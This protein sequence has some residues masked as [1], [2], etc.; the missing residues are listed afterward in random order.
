MAVEAAYL[1]ALQDATELTISGGQLA[2]GR[3]DI[4][5]IFDPQ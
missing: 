4:E 2:I 3:T 1:A 5:L